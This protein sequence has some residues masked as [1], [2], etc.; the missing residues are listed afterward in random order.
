MALY[1]TMHSYGSMILFPWGHDGSLSHNA[2]AL[3]TV[4]VAM[5]EEIDAL[6]LPNF[7]NYVVGNSVLVIGYGAAGAAEDYAHIVGVPLAYT[8]ELPGLAGGFEGF[9][10][11]PIYIQQVVI[12]TWAGIAAGARR[13]GQLF[14]SGAML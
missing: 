3:L 5:A 9:H 2:F 11:D 1:L 4:G 6:K 14:R 7:P 12:E 13:A 10:L 8:Y